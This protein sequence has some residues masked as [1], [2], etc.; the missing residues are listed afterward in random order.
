MAVI[1][2]ERVEAQSAAGSAAILGDK[3]YCRLPGIS[4]QSKRNA[5]KA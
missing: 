1:L 5:D 3:R 4:G 2:I